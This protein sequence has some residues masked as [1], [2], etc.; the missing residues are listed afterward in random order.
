MQPLEKPS[1]QKQARLPRQAL[2]LVDFLEKQRGYFTYENGPLE[3]GIRRAA[4][5]AARARSA[6]IPIIIVTGHFSRT[7]FPEILKA[8]GADHLPACKKGTSAFTSPDFQTM[9]NAL[10]IDTLIVG[11]WIRHICV[12]ATIGDALERDYAVQTTDHI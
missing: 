11:G 12:M 3:E 2:V 7:V 6:G 10:D 4:D 8:A 1:P 9:I 5:I